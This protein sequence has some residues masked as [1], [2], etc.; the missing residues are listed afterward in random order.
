MPIL[1]NI[2]NQKEY[3]DTLKLLTTTHGRMVVRLS[4]MESHPKTSRFEEDL[5]LMLRGVELLLRQEIP[6]HQRQRG[7]TR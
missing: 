7:P 6:E 5:V 2:T 3:Q 4:E 1:D